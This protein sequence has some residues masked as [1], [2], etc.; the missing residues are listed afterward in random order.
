LFWLPAWAPGRPRERPREAASLLCLCPE[1]QP[2]DMAK[3][4]FPVEQNFSHSTLWG[5]G[6]RQ[7]SAAASRG[8][9]L[10]LPGR[11]PGQPKPVDMD[12]FR[13]HRARCLT[14]CLPEKFGPRGHLRWAPSFGIHVRFA[15]TGPKSCGIGSATRPPGQPTAPLAARRKSAEIN[16]NSMAS[17][18][19]DPQHHQREAKNRKCRVP[20]G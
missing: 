2:V 5:S 16:R 14:T 15:G 13:S 20:C 3:T 8:R 18:Q 17:L 7:S 19:N 6:R 1:P 11:P 9:S 12:I 4:W 10:G